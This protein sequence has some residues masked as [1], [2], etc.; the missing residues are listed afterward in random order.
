MSVNL[1]DI[2]F[3]GFNKS[4]IALDQN[5]GEVIWDWKSPQGW[6][7]VSL[8]LTDEE[9]L[10]VSVTGYTYCL[11]PKTGQQLWFNELPGYGTGVAS[12]I[13]LNNPGS[14]PILL[15]AASDDA[16]AASAPVGGVTT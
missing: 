7:Y 12:L 3:T 11:D 13:S 6:G 15:A 4:V 14:S 10:I 2:V 16:A 8:L 5:T 1:K 9:H